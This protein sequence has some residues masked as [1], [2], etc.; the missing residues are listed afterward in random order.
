M[1]EDS[2]SIRFCLSNVIQHKLSDDLTKLQQAG[3]SIQVERCL[4]NC[5]TCRRSAHYTRNGE[6]YAL[7]SMDT[8]SNSVHDSMIARI[9]ELEIQMESLLLSLRNE[10]DFEQACALNARFVQLAKEMI[11]L[12]SKLERAHEEHTPFNDYASS[13]VI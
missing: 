7:K 5:G 9:Q 10:D 4:N 12:R 11:D 13:E 3:C 8:G 1:S 2:N 6:T